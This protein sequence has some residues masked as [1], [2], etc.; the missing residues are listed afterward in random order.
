MP[1][2]RQNCASAGWPVLPQALQQRAVPGC[3]SV[4][5]IGAGSASAAALRRCEPSSAVTMPVGTAGTSLPSRI[6]DEAISRPRSVRGVM[7][8]K[9]TVVIVVTAQ[10]IAV[11]MLVKPCSGPSTPYIGVPA[12]GTTISTKP[13][14]TRILRGLAAMAEARK[15]ISLAWRD[16]L[17]MR[18]HLVPAPAPATL[19]LAEALRVLR[20]L[21][22]LQ[23]GRAAAVFMRRPRGPPA[24]P[25]P[26]P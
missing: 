8:P 3:N 17:K 2:R 26:R 4:R 5:R 23:R 18:N 24:R 14:K 6:I 1:Q 10:Y 22:G 12:T 9:P 25:V 20:V 21:G 15:C 7:S 16:S 19:R 13:R 11:G